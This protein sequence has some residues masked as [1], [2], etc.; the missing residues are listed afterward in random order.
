[1]VLWVLVSYFGF[2]F[3]IEHQ[4]LVFFQRCFSCRTSHHSRRP[5]WSKTPPS[6]ASPGSSWR[7]WCCSSPR[8]S[9][10]GAKISESIVGES[11]RLRGSTC[12]MRIFGSSNLPRKALV[13]LDAAWW[14]SWLRWC[15]DRSGLC[16]ML[17][18][19]LGLEDLKNFHLRPRRVYSLVD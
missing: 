15:R 12:T 2:I 3:L 4:H 7:N 11:C 14:R 19:S 8:W 1:M 13:E 18:S 10:A 5:S 16:L 6:V 17:G 9:M